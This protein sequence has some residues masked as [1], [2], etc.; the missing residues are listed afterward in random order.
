M[1]AEGGRLRIARIED[2][3]FR[4]DDVDRADHALVVRDVGID[5]LQEGQQGR[6]R[7]RRIGA[8]DEAVGLGVGL[9]VIEFHMRVFDGD[10]D[11]DG[12]FRALVM[13]VEI[14][15]AF[16]A[17]DAVRDVRDLRLH[18]LLGGVEQRRL[19]GLENIAAVFL[20]Q[21]AHPPLADG[22]GAHLGFQ[23]VLHDVEADIGK[24]QIP[25]VAAQLALLVD[26]HRRNAQR[27][28]PDFLGVGIVA[29]RH[30]AAD[31][32]LMALHRGPGDQRAVVEDR[33]ID[34]DV[35]VLVAER[36]H[37]VVED[38]VAVVNV[39]AEIAHQVL[40]HRAEREG[41][42]RQV[43]GLL[44][45][46]AVG[47]VEPGDEILGL[48]QDRRAR[49]LDHGRAHLVGDRAEGAGQYRHQD[50]IDGFLVGAHDFGP[51]QSRTR[52]SRPLR[53]IKS[54]PYW[55]VTAS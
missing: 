7:A 46:V 32:G 45:H 41:E 33:L 52:S 1:I 4:N 24:N 13:A 17:I 8:V 48:A 55:S 31:I 49:G 5:E 43:L 28:L 40:A 11:A 35:V 12:E 50:R 20:Q 3:A 23:I 47:V 53:Y 15:H 44:Q 51:R 34:G 37:V 54:E 9:G 30:G 6:R 2:G 10:G 16:A 39:V 27:L 18:H 22:A 19:V 21:R 38:H 29:A 42:D 25:D 14:D 26:F 36:E